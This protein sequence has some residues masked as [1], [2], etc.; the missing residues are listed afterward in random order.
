MESSDDLVDD[1]DDEIDLDGSCVVLLLLRTPWRA[2]AAGALV[3]AADLRR[4][5]LAV[6]SMVI[7]YWL[8]GCAV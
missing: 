5:S 7:T 4:A 1:V 3:M 6:D 2:V 8:F